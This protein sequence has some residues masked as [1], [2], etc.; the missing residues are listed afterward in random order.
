MSID[1]STKSKERDHENTYAY[2]SPVHPDRTHNLTKVNSQA[3]FE[4]LPLTSLA[5]SIPTR[6]QLKQAR[7]AKELKYAYNATAFEVRNKRDTNRSSF[8]SGL[9][10]KD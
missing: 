5:P 9:R 6:H 1:L 4:V 3:N 7:L 10:S 2:Q 8:S